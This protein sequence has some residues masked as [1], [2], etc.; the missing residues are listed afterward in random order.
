[1]FT[2]KNILTIKYRDFQ[3]N[4]I[5]KYFFLNLKTEKFKLN[6][7]FNLMKKSLIFNKYLFI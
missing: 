4:L 5:K 7:M 1:M 6:L 2:L 3:Q